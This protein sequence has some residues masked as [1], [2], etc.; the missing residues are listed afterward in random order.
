MM[1]WERV[2][3]EFLFKQVTDDIIWICD[4]RA[5]I[6]DSE[7]DKCAGYSLSYVILREKALQK[8]K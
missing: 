8:S 5:T 1:Q 6:N 7:L 2:H 3:W 4:K